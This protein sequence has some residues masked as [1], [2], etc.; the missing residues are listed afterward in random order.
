MKLTRTLKIH[1]ALF[2]VVPLINVTFLVVVF[3]A[4]SSRFV[5]QPGMAISLPVSGFTLSPQRDAKIVSVT[6]A[7]VP[8]IYFRDRRVSME[9]LRAQLA[10]THGRERSLIIKADRGTPYDLVVQI[11]N[12]GLK[13]GFSV[14]LATNPEKP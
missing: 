10:E 8:S 1:P 3:F 9:E 14:I 13:L 12:E 4:L 5:L 6:A 7:P 2:N 11:M